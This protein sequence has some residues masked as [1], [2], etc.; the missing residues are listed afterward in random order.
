MVQQQ[1]MRF[2]TSR[3]ECNSRSCLHF[4]RVVQWMEYRFPTPKLASPIL[5][6]GTIH[7]NM[8]KGGKYGYGKWQGL[9]V[10]EVLGSGWRGQAGWVGMGGGAGGPEIPVILYTDLINRLVG[11]KHWTKMSY[12]ES[13]KAVD[14][15]CK[16][17]NAILVSAGDDEHGWM[18]RA[19][20]EA[21]EAQADAVVFEGL[22]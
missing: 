4:A 22:S 10:Y 16:A 11:P 19:Y 1:H 5:A 14:D 6:V 7:I 3:S 13:G 15:W 12:E 20:T 8:T 21:D 17:H 18:S 9:D 2:I